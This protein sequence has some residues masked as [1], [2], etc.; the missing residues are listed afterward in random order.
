MIFCFMIYF[1]SKCSVTQE[2]PGWYS[3]TKGY[4]VKF[5]TI[6]NQN[7]QI[8]IIGGILDY[9]VVMSAVLFFVSLFY[10]LYVNRMTFSGKNLVSCCLIFVL[11]IVLETKNV[12]AAKSYVQSWRLIYKGKLGYSC[13]SKYAGKV[14]EAITV[15]NN[16]K[17]NVIVSSSAPDVVIRGSGSLGADVNGIT[18]ANGVIYLNQTNWSFLT[19]TERKNLAMHE[20][21]HAL[22][23]AHNPSTGNI[24]YHA[25]TARTTLSGDDKAS[26]ETSYGRSYNVC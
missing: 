22:G 1:S 23:L 4:P 12:Y 2:I 15:W 19:D 17:N 16:Y 20:I 26:Y 5:I 24:M 18:Y 21:G 7:Y 10:L 8:S 3:I 14:A 11:I 13:E 6:T 9:L 25:T